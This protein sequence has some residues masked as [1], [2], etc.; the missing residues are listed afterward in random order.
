M[1]NEATKKNKKTWNLCELFGTESE[2][3]GHKLFFFSSAKQSL[4]TIA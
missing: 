2:S 4:E 3:L 1:I